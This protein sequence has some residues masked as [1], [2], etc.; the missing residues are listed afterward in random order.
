MWAMGYT[1]STLTQLYN[2][3]SWLDP[4]KTLKPLRS[5]I[6]KSLWP[7]QALMRDQSLCGQLGSSQALTSKA[8]PTSSP[9]HRPLLYWPY[10]YTTLVNDMKIIIQTGKISRKNKIQTGYKNLIRRVLIPVMSPWYHHKKKCFCHKVRS[11]E[12]LTQSNYNKSFLSETCIQGN[13]S[14]LRKHDGSSV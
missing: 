6:S 10:V 7:W 8:W 9:F 1:L 5:S 14:A 13:F 2:T 3:D 11:T 12:K 4:S